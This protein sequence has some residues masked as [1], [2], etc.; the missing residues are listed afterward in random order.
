MKNILF[1]IVIPVFNTKIEYINEAVYSCLR[2]TYE[3]LEIIIIDDGSNEECAKELDLL[4]ELDSRVIVQHK[5]NE[6]VSAARNTGIQKSKGDYVLFLDADDS[7]E[8]NALEILITMLDKNSDIDVIIFS[9]SRDYFDKKIPITPLYENNKVFW[10]D[11]DNRQLQEDVLVSPLDKNILVFPY[12]KCIRREILDVMQPCF[13][14]EIAM[15]EDVVFSMKLFEYTQKVVYIDQVLYHYRQLWNSAVNK[16]RINAEDEQN[17]LLKRILELIEVSNNSERLM[18]GFYYEVFYAMQRIIIMKFFHPKATGS[19][20]K[21]RIECGKVF[22][23]EPYKHVFNYIDIKSMSRNQR[24]KAYLL[25]HHMYA[26]LG[27]LRNIYFR[28]PGQK[29]I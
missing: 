10:G 14:E 17:L 26:I 8:P 27:I 3:N 19:F 12:C 28:L 5:N 25:K 7:F 29:Q 1:S 24:I 2:Q 11:G 16:Y 22:S 13:P 9:L 20:F 21:R 6:G 15:C 23:T 18:I 4:K